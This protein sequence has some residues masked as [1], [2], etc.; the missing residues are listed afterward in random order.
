MNN[1]D[2]KIIDGLKMYGAMAP[3]TMALKL[4]AS[5]HDIRNRL[6]ILIFKELI[7]EVLGS[8]DKQLF[9]IKGR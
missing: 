6:G 4:G 9:K 7:E 1:L 8:R 2:S 3:R 5:E